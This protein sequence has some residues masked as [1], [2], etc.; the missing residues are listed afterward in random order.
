MKSHTSAESLAMP[1]CCEIAKIMFGA[2]FE[3]QVKKI[4]MSNNT[5]SRRIK[6]MSEDVEVEIVDK[7]KLVDMFASQIDESPDIG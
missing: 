5:I 6:E 2:E 4:P 1:T 3:T 7:L